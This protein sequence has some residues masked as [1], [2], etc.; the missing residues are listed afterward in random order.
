M[1]GLEGWGRFS[2]DRLLGPS[3][4]CFTHS[5]PAFRLLTDVLINGHDCLK[6]LKSLDCSALPLFLHCV[7]N[8]LQIKV[9]LC[10]VLD[11]VESCSVD[12][13]VRFAHFIIFF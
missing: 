13:I 1:N 12:S 4:S 10:L 2:H 6:R 11:L 8:L 5:V 7:S 3:E 9:L